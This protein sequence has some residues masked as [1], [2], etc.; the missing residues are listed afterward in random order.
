MHIDD[1]VAEFE[2][3][4]SDANMIFHPPPDIDPDTPAT[5]D[6]ELSYDFDIESTLPSKVANDKSRIS[7]NER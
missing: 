4:K 6:P 1:D 2:E 7:N 5:E 3:T